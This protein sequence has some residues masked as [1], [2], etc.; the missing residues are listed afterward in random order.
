M[1]HSINLFFSIIWWQLLNSILLLV[2]NKYI[3]HLNQECERHLDVIN[4]I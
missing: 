2:S 3:E 4:V 1:I